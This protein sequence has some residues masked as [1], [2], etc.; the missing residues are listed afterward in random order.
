LPYSYV[1]FAAQGN[2][3]INWENPQTLHGFIRLVTRAVYGTFKSGTLVGYS[4]RERFFHIFLL[5]ETLFIDTTK[6]GLLLFAS[7]FV[8]LFFTNRRQFIFLFLAFFFTGPFFVYY[9]SFPTGNDFYLGTIERFYLVPY[10]FFFLF[11]SWGIIGISQLLQR[12]FSIILKKK[13]QYPISNVFILL[14]ILLFATSAPKLLPL[15]HDQTAENVGHDVLETV[16]SESLLLMTED[17]RLFNTEYIYFTSKNAS[18]IKLIHFGLL[19]FPF[20]QQYVKKRFPVLD[21]PDNGD[22]PEYS[23]VFIENNA[24]NYTIFADASYAITEEYRWVPVGLI[25]RLYSIDDILD[26]DWYLEENE[27]LFSIYQDPLSGALGKYKHVMLADVLRIYGNARREV[28][29]ILFKL[30]KY[31]EARKYF[32]KAVV[33][34]DEVPENHL[35]LIMSQIMLKS[36]DKAKVLFNRVEERFS[37]FPD[38]YPVGALLYKE[39]FNDEEKFDF[40]NELYEEKVRQGQL[41]LEEL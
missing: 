4:I 2:P 1:Y 17:T 25:Y 26:T 18:N 24:E 41:K 23:K 10:F 14:P 21:M 35:Q 38:V 33:L 27:R 3:P 6:A 20:Y 9:A 34:Q 36:C 22:S 29:K 13:K 30:G 16:S 5:L 31:D 37:M 11:I 40:Y 8:Y 32:E 7:G 39:C 19:R 12:F 28:G 15:R